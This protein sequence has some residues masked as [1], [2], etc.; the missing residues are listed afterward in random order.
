[1]KQVLLALAL[2]LCASTSFAQ[3]VP[4]DSTLCHEPVLELYDANRRKLT[5]G[6]RPRGKVILIVR[7]NPACDIPQTF[8][9]KGGSYFHARGT[10]SLRTVRFTGPVVD[11]TGQE[12]LFRAG[13]R[14]IFEVLDLNCYNKKSKEAS[15]FSGTIVKSWSLN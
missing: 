5:K 15:K 3:Q 8:S 6:A 14:L 10:T 11:F 4:V 9:V 13:D 7:N 12:K 2:M 1:M